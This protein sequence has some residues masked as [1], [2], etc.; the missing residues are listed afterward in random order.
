MTKEKAIADATKLA[1]KFKLTIAVVNDPI[2]NNA[3]SDPDG[4]WG[5]CPANAKD[6]NGKFILFRWAEETI[7]INPA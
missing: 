2:S 3:E 7:I 5:Y 6:T 1:K 4:P